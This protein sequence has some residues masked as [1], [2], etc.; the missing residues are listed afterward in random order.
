M[1]PLDPSLKGKNVIVFADAEIFNKEVSNPI[2]AESRE[3]LFIPDLQGYN[4]D[5]V[6]INPKHPRARV[7]QL[8]MDCYKQNPSGE[9]FKKAIDP[10]LNA[11]SD[12]EQDL[13]DEEMGCSKRWIALCNCLPCLEMRIPSKTIGKIMSWTT[14]MTPMLMMITA[15]RG[16]SLISTLTQWLTANSC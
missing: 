1:A 10:Y 7:Y 4:H 14:S 2:D 12:G 8:L 5:N 11:P 6:R 15:I 13:S 16:M 3:N 9:S